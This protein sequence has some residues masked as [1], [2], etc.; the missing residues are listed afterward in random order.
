MEAGQPGSYLTLAE[1]TPVNSSD[2]EQ[3]GEVARVLADAEEDIFDGLILDTKHGDR[4]VDAQRV[5]SIHERLVVLSLSAAEAHALP[6]PPENPAA[7]KVT[8]DD[9]AEAPTEHGAK[10]L[11]RRLWDW[12]SG[13]Y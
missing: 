3:V 1:G 12:V 6:A 11:G 13:R 5:A 7:M 4:F 8:A 10:G 9:V 2:G